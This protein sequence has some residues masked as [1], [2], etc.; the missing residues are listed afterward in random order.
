MFYLIVGLVLAS[1]ILIVA[2]DFN[3]KDST[4]GSIGFPSTVDVYDNSSM[5]KNGSLS[6]NYSD[7][8]VGFWKSI[9]GRLGSMVGN[10]VNVFDWNSWR[11]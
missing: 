7:V 10:V 5:D 3:L 4:I 6:G 2:V 1:F 11:N 9:G 8:N